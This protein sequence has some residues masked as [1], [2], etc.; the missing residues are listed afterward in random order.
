V[1]ATDQLGTTSVPCWC[2]WS[3]ISIPTESVRRDRFDFEFRV[4]AIAELYRTNGSS[5]RDGDDTQRR[6]GRNIDR[7]A[8]RNRRDDDCVCAGIDQLQTGDGK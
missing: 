7:G 8:N 1:G 5:R 6:A 3:T 2:C 4:A